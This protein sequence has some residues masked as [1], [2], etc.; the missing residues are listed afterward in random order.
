MKYVFYFTFGLILSIGTLM[1]QVVSDFT[2]NAENW[3]S[4]GDGSF[5]W[6][7]TAGNP[8]PC[9]RVDDDATGDINYALAPPKFMGNWASGSTASDYVSAD[10]FLHRSSGGYISNSFVFKIIGPGGEATAIQSAQPTLDAWTTY[11]AF[12]DPANWSVSGDW[13]LLLQ[14]ITAFIVTAEYINGDEYVRID[15]VTL[16][17]TPEII[18]IVPVICSDFDDGG[19]D[20]WSFVSTGGV[21]NTTFSGQPGRSIK[22]SDG[23][24]V[25]TA[26]P[27]VKYLGDWTQLDGYAAHII[28]DVNISSHTGD[29]LIKEY[30]IRISGPDGSAKF[31]LSN[32]SV[33][34][35]IH[36][37][38]T[39]IFPID[40]SYWIMESGTW[41]ELLNWVDHM[42]IAIEFFD[43][44]EVVW[45]DNFCVSNLPPTA[46]FTVPSQI[47]FIGNPIQFMD[48]SQS[49]PSLWHW[50]FGDMQT[51]IQKNPMH[52]Y[53][54]SGIFDVK[55]KVGNHFGEDSIIKTELI[56]ILA[57]DQCLKFE[58]NFDDNTIYP[59]YVFKNGTWSESNGQLR[60]SSNHYTS[61]DF[62]DGCFAVTGSFLWENYLLS[63]DIKSTDN[64][65]IGFVF[66]WQDEQNMYMFLWDK[67]DGVRKLV[68]WVD[69]I[70]VILAEDDIPYITSQWYGFRILSDNGKIVVAIDGDEIFSV[71]DNTFTSG[72]AGL[73]CWG[74]QS[75]YWDNFRIECAASETLF[76]PTG[77]SGISTHVIPVSESMESLFN[78]VLS[79]LVILQ[80]ADGMFWPGQNINTLGAWDT[81]K[82][83]QIKATDAFELTISG[84]KETNQTLQ[85]ATGWNLIPVISECNADVTELFQNVN[86]ELVKEVAGTA[87]FWPEF[88]I[89]SLTLLEP[90]KAYFVLLGSEE[91]ITFPACN[92]LKQMSISRDIPEDLFGFEITKT[93]VTHTIAIPS[94]VLYTNDLLVNGYLIASNEDGVCY[95]A[96]LLIG[97]NTSIT[98]FGDDPTT[99][100]K[101][102]YAEDEEITFKFIATPSEEEVELGISYDSQFDHSGMFLGN[103][104]SVISDVTITTSTIRGV[105]IY[106]NPTQGMLTIDGLKESATISV[107]DAF[108][109]EIRQ[110]E[111]LS[112]G[113]INLTNQ[114]KGIYF[115][116]VESE[117]QTYFQKLIIN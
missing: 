52:T 73:Y 27:P 96:T 8:A 117:G 3:R 97:A 116:R 47:D 59:A 56:E 82:G 33:A 108:E 11:T 23:S 85:L 94:K 111:M 100:I 1:A 87:V 17:I 53:Q 28:M 110:I 35:A 93:A 88:E 67:E 89:Y 43:G 77:W 7:E 22:I 112:S 63:C 92:G 66:N 31:L 44:T 4:E 79:D 102:G 81:H 49:G 10:I 9:F 55:L 91:N 5:Y 57:I 83:Y 90:G 69:G 21:S 2:D 114:A 109:N 84:T 19:Y 72:K 76:I 45:L 6:E 26:Y 16:S 15:N 39:F 32:E 38:H 14:Q 40:E 60:Q 68:K 48:K 54:T 29:P 70:E 51:S 74:N 80:N 101:D 99:I 75:A 41:D 24:G 20:G 46:D 58:D 105:N 18:P 104:M 62:L 50:D 95:G 103:G 12:L 78:P 64:D 42:E 115:I 34:E 30:L 98:L 36:Q 13:D 25:S 86:V 37:W 113:T 107:F 106:P 65:Y 71:Y 61:N